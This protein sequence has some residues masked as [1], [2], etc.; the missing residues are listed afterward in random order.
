M[1]QD[2]DSK[3][4]WTSAANAAGAHQADLIELGLLAGVLG[5]PLAHLIALVEQLDLLEVFERLA[6]RRLGLV[7]LSFQFVGRALEILAPLHGRL[8]VG[9]I[10]EMRG[11]MN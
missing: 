11:I 4:W 1:P 8:G 6:Q 5:R 2:V 3:S 7:E 10:G 9:R